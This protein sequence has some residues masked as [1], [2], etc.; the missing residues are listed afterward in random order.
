MLESGVVFDTLR[1]HDLHEAISLLELHG[2]AARVVAGGTDVMVQIPVGRIKPGV[3]VSLD[4]IAGLRQLECTSDR[5]LT[6]GALATH[7]DVV[8]SASCARSYPALVEGC[9]LVGSVQLR[10]LATVGGNLCNASPSAD[11]TPPLV[12]YG[13]AVT[14][15]GPRGER[16]MS[17]EEFLVGPGK[18][19]LAH[20][21]VLVRIDVP[22]P[23]LRS[24]ARY[25]R[26]TP[27]LAM[28]IAFVNVAVMVILE[29]DLETCREARIALGAVAPTVVRA[30]SAEAALREQALTP[31]LFEEAG[32]IAASEC[33]PITDV[34]GS[35]DG[36]IDAV[37]MLVRRCLREALERAKES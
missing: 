7:N 37:Q 17:L 30:R 25:E 13:A 14:L 32:R 1:P 12:V 29:N 9:R 31:E 19:A 18:T 10:N 21:E 15:L 23:T 2:E 4:R 5:G 34:R 28:D 20:D 3:L 35:A 24:G 33:S 22:M 36:R 27:R 6:L 26:T 8:D 16:T 11:A